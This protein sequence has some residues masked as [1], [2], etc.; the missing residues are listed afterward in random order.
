MQTYIVEQMYN[1]E[2]IISSH[3]HRPMRYRRVEL[4]LQIMLCYNHTP[5]CICN[6]CTSA[7][8]FFSQFDMDLSLLIEHSQKCFDTNVLR[9]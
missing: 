1:V 5:F 3:Q 9:L 4:C 6:T 8:T 7:L 2:S